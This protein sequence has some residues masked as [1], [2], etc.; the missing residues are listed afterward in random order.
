MEEHMVLYR[1]YR[2]KSF[3]EVTG[4]EHIVETLKN[5]VA[6]N[7]LSH[8]YLFSG[9]RGSGKTTLARLL[10]KAANCESARGPTKGEP[11]NACSSCEEINRGRA[12]DLV[13]IDAASNRGIDEMRELRDSVAFVP[14]KLK[15]KVFVIDEAHQLTKEAA[16]ALL[17]TLE[18]PPAHVLFIL[19]TTEA[20]K[21]IP[22]IASRCQRF[23][24]RKL[25]V[26]EISG[27]L[28]EVTKAEKASVNKEA[29]QLIALNAGGSLRDALGLLDKVLT[30]Y[31][32]LDTKEPIG[33]AVIKD[34]L[35]LVDI[36]LVG[37]FVQLLADKKAGEA[38]DFLNKNLQAGMDPQEFSKNLVRYLRHT[39]VL[40]INPELSHIFESELTPEQL[41]R[42]VQQ[43]SQ[44]SK[45]LL[46][47]IVENFMR[48]E[49]EMKYASIVQLPLE[50]AIVESCAKGLPADKVGE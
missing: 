38:I 47:N 16:N 29:L 33:A 8:A 27:K 28:A 13:E 9:P 49:Q 11:C 19:A 6:G 40:S 21:M 34:L 39:L 41:E 1:K 36:N 2:P 15:Y 26:P 18:E 7:L 23:D 25:T 12:I 32:I 42:M 3:S 10:A 31:S 43:A 50:L 17:K 20:H 35:G 44:F 30:F 37:E 24:F 4:Q 48:A 14:A 22:T 46:P 45:D 5:A